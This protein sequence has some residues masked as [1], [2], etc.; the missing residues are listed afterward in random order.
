MPIAKFPPV[1][2]S[3]EQGLLALGGDLH[4]ESLILAYSQGIFP[5]PISDEY[6]LAWFSPDPRGVLDLKNLHLPKRLKRYAKKIPLDFQ[7]NQDFHS[8]V[9]Y[10]A[11]VKRSDHSGTWITQDIKDA[12]QALFDM[13]F[14]Y[15][16][17]AYQDKKLVAGIYGTCIGD[18]ISGES[19]FTFIDHG[20]KLCLIYLMKSLEVAGI[21]WLDTQMVTPVVESLGGIEISREDFMK[22]LSLRKNVARTHIFIEHEQHYFSL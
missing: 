7:Y 10:C 20:S 9:E 6:P 19:M 15:C 18:C 22:R 1:S 2:E 11:S 3:D 13:G 17:G 12:Y 8:I 21:N 16:L 4:P 5:W 14:A